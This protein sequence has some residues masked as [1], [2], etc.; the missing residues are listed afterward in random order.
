MKTPLTINPRKFRVLL[1]KQFAE[2][3]RN[4][5]ML[6][7]HVPFFT[8]ELEMTALGCSFFYD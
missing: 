2:V 7:N 8:W 6:C 4:F 1:R 5:R 3:M